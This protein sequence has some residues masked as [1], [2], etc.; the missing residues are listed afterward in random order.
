[1]NQAFVY[2]CGHRYHRDLIM[3]DIHRWSVESS[4][5]INK[6]K[7]PT[8]FLQAGLQHTQSRLLLSGTDVYSRRT[9][10]SISKFDAF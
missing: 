5:P 4:T 7:T 8:L 2:Y 10:T 9:L 3:V 6:V 1:M